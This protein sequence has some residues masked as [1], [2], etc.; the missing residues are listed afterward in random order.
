MPSRFVCALSIRGCYVCAI[1][2]RYERRVLLFKTGGLSPSIWNV[3]RMY[4]FTSL[5]SLQKRNDFISKWHRTK[6]RNLIRFRFVV[7]VTFFSNLFRSK[8]SQIRVARASSIL[9]NGVFYFVEIYRSRRIFFVHTHSLEGNCDFTLAE[10]LM[11]DAIHGKSA[12]ITNTRD[13]NS[14]FRIHR[15]T[16]ASGWR[17][18]FCLFRGRYLH[19]SF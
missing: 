6:G 5:G 15:V 16:I 9:A 17:L 7:V 14:Q 2:A 10:R 13:I 3:W 18:F 11:G 19:T 12:N 1:Y 4:A 8:L